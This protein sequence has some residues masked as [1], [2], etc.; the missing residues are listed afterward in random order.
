EILDGERAA[1]WKDH[2]VEGDA[3]TDDVPER[4]IEA[5]EVAPGEVVRSRRLGHVELTCDATVH[6]EVHDARGNG[7]E[8]HAGGEPEWWLPA[9]V[10]QRLE[11]GRRVIGAVGSGARDAEVDTKRKSQLTADKP[12]T[13]RDG[14]RHDHRL[15]TQPE[16]QAPGGHHGDGPGHG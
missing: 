15:G 11:P 13:N 5:P 2:R 4:A 1:E 9:L 10:V 6:Q 14:D 12:L 8:R 16:H 7:E 3:E